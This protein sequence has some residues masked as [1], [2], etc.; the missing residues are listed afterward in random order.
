MLKKENHRASR[1][2][3]E[4][5]RLSVERFWIR[6]IPTSEI[7]K[8]LDVS[9]QTVYRDLEELEK[10][11]SIEVRRSKLKPVKLAYLELR[12]LK[13]LLW[14]MLEKEIRRDS[15]DLYTK[16]AT[17]DRIF[18]IMKEENL[19]ACLY[20]EEDEEPYTPTTPESLAEWRRKQ[21]EILKKAK[22][23]G[24]QQKKEELLKARAITRKT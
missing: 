18:K 8:R 6:G 22:R 14:D 9:D 5:R 2:E 23:I 11:L 20:L 3:I 7:A 15:N 17:I 12:E 24:E 13:R 21:N 10:S 1:S 19:L 4:A 16:L